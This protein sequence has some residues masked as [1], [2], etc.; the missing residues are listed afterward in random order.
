MRILHVVPSY[1][2]AVRY[3]GPIYSVHA[4]C[5]ALAERDHDVHVFTTNIDGPGHSDVP[6]NKPVVIDGVTVRYFDC[7]FGRRLYRSPAMR[8]TLATEAMAFDVL[9]LHS[10]FLWPTLAAARAASNAQVPYVL[11]PRGMLVQ[12]LIRRKSRLLKTL[13]VAL[14][15]RSNLSGAAAIHLTSALE[16]IEFEKLNIR[17]RRIDVIANGVDVP[18]PPPAT[19][20]AIS[21]RPYVLSLG[22]INW[23]KGLDRLIAAMI[24]VPDT[25]L[26]IA[27]NDEEN[28]QPRLEALVND[29]KLSERVRF[30]GPV[31]D[32]D[33]WRLLRSAS[34][35]ALPSYSENFGNA[36]LEA[37][38][39]GCP[40]V[41]TPEVG[42]ASAIGG[43]GAGI[44]VDGEPGKLGPAMARLIS[45][46]KCG[47]AMG[48]AGK[49]LAERDYSWAQI[50]AQAEQLY[51][52]CRKEQPRCA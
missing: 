19:L 3:G 52:D 12:D 50:A 21:R 11:A 36:V 47:A 31:G 45:D 7:G 9:H 33:K 18:T 17:V 24:H 42:L 39:V 16:R 27:G 30:L 40:V 25:D 48:V 2:P 49:N 26:L 41:V 35:F 38:A 51:R 34:L 37:M 28:Y 14:F 32:A 22:R 10:V 20:S 13:W 43:A 1:L 46:P 8:R 5:R 44:V 15:E 6:L 29:M 23:K 4:L